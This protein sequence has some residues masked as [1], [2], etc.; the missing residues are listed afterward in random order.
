MVKSS[1]DLLGFSVLSQESSQDSLSSDPEDLGGHS[2]FDSTS[3]FTSTSVVTFAL[4]LKMESCTGTRMD[5][6]FAL[7]DQAVLDKF[8]NEDS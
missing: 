3:T 1:V 5:Y 2:A 4:G 8:A 6:L 7:H